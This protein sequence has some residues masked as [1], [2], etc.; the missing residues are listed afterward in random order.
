[1]P[2][3]NSENIH[4][5]YEMSGSGEPLVLLHGFSL[6]RRMWRYQVES[7]AEKYMVITPDARGHGLSDAPSTNYAREDRTTDLENLVKHLGLD[8]FHLLG[9]SMG[10]GDALAYAIDYHERL[11]S[12]TLAATVAAGWRPPKRFRDFAAPAR[13]MGVVEA[14]RLY[15]ESILSYYDR[16]H[17]HLRIEMEEMMNDFGGAPWLDPMKGKYI[18]RDDISLCN[19]LRIPTLVVVGQ[20]DIFFRPLAEQL[21]GLIEHSKFEIIKEAGHMV[22]ME[23]PDQF[24]AVV[25]D[26]LKKCECKNE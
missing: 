17:T 19:T 13:E 9:F 10:G 22:N 20:R 8:R 1:M 15:M 26:F 4:L 14:K 5:Y 11:L 21:S 2:Y 18:K 12:L 25:I 16:K 23:A 6:D 3:F 7:F 24:N